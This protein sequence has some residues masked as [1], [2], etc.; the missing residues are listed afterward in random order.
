[1][2]WARNRLDA[3][4]KG[5]VTLPPVVTTLQ[6]G[7]LDAWEPGLVRK[8]WNARPELM[9][10][11]GTMFGGY[12]AALADQILAFAAMTVVPADKIFRTANLRVDF[13]KLI[14]GDLDIEGRVT[15]QSSS[16]IAVEADLRMRD[17]GDLAARGYAQQILVPAPP[18]LA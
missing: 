3:L 16:L 17:G 2:S 7:G 10:A 14:R 11:D 6:L 4:V 13:F 1:V 5:G 9:N 12:L 15:T 18:G 8:R